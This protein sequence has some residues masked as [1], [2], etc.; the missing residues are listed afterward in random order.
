MEC[1]RLSSYQQ[2][3]RLH[4]YQLKLTESSFIQ[5]SWQRSRTFRTSEC[6]FNNIYGHTLDRRRAFLAIMCTVYVL[7]MLKP[8][9]KM[10][11]SLPPRI[12]LLLDCIF[13]ILRTLVQ[14]LNIHNQHYFITLCCADCGVENT[15]SIHAFIFVIQIR[16]CD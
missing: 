10:F 4:F 12:L 2:F 15:P 13:F 14:S 7:A 8:N 5:S 9:H 16:V 3:R 1:C 6:F 11:H